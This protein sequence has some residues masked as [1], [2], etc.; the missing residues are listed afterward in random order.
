M[1]VTG[2]G[3]W[4]REGVHGDS[5]GAG[6]PEWTEERTW[7]THRDSQGPHRPGCGGGCEGRGP[8]SLV[9]RQGRG[10]LWRPVHP[11]AYR[12]GQRPEVGMPPCWVRAHEETQG[13]AVS[14]QPRST[15]VGTLRGPCI[16]QAFNRRC[17]NRHLTA[18]VWWS[19]SAHG[20]LTGAPGFIPRLLWG[21]SAPSAWTPGQQRSPQ[22]RSAT[23]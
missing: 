6:G 20:V 17:L 7:E 12:P 19:A 16:Q 10:S 23:L 4:A 11:E 5:A 9:I 1:A 15:V 22:P 13:Q 14:A 2:R 18:A 8:G 3:P 21:S